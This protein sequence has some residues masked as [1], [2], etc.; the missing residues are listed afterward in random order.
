MSPFPIVI[1]NPLLKK[2]KNFPEIPQKFP[3]GHSSFSIISRNHSLLL[4]FPTQSPITSPSFPF[5]RT[6]DF[7][8]QSRAFPQV[9]MIFSP[10]FVSL[11]SHSFILIFS[12]Q[13]GIHSLLQ[14]QLFFLSTVSSFIQLVQ[15]WVIGSKRPYL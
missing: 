5:A 7:L 1:K 15:F 8:L 9:C 4:H 11:Y 2:K 13:F 14:R 3:H 12:A 10:F 6:I